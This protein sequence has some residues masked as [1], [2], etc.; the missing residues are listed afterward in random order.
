[1]PRTRLAS[2]SL[3][4][5]RAGWSAAPGRLN[6]VRPR[7]CRGHRS[8][9]LSGTQLTQAA[10]AFQPCHLAGCPFHAQPKADGMGEAIGVTVQMP[11]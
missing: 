10:A 7:D 8:Y 6:G 9:N 5:L 11:E 3:S 1:M 2:D 4:H